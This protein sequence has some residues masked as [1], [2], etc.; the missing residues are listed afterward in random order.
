MTC[1]LGGPK[2]TWFFNLWME[3]DL[4]LVCGPKM[5]CFYCG[6]RLIWFLCG[7]SKLTWFLYSGRKSLRVSVN[8]EID[9]VFVLV[10]IDLI[11]VWEVEL[12]LIA[13]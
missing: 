9:L 6:D 1:F 5:T 8:V 10:E 2:G 7:W 4:F 12:D 13:V 3:I 11:S